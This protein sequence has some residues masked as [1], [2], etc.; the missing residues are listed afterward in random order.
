MLVFFSEGLFVLV[1]LKRMCV[2]ACVM[3]VG[4]YIPSRTDEDAIM[5]NSRATESWG[6]GTN[7]PE[8]P[9]RILGTRGNPRSMLGFR[10]VI[11][12]LTFVMYV[13]S[14]PVNYWPFY[15]L[16]RNVILSSPCDSPRVVMI[17]YIQALLVKK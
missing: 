17:F 2:C 6:V 13:F 7:S 9:P 11:N 12:W 1:P 16:L 5:A 8:A 4:V 14:C 10:T 3:S 15:S